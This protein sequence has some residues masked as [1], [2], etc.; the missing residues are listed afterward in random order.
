MF[1][2]SIA[3]IFVI[4]VIQKFMFYIILQVCLFLENVALVCLLF[5]FAYYVDYCFLNLD[6]FRYF[7]IVLSLNIWRRC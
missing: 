3:F 1:Q 6:Y 2:I 5:R 4:K 7:L